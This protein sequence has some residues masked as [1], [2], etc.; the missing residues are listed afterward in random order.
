MMNQTSEGKRCPCPCHKFITLLVVLFGLNFLLK[1]LGVY[2]DDVSN[3]IW[4]ILVILGGL[5][6]MF[7]TM[8][9]CCD[10]A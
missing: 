2:G 4:P 7:S 5:K 3:I 9:K 8:C 10:R 1:T 6:S